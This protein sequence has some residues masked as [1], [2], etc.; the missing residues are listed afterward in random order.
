MNCNFP[1]VSLLPA[2]SKAGKK[3]FRWNRTQT[4][5]SE[6]VAKNLDIKKN[7][8]IFASFFLAHK[9]SS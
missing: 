6:K 3:G 5:K 8:S 1:K 2:E 9:I 4:A 7:I